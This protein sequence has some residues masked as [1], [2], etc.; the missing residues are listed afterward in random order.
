MT[1]NASETD[2]DGPGVGGYGGRIRR[3][4]MAADAHF[5]QISNAL[6]RDPRVSFKAK[7]I[8]GLIS[9]HRDGFGIKPET[10]AKAGTEGVAAIKTALQ[11]LER[12]G[13][14][15]RAQA[16]RED[17][18]LG[19]VV[20]YITDMPRSEP[21]DDN[22][23]PVPTS[24]VGHN[25]RSEPVD[26]YPLADEPPAVN[27][28]HKNTNS[29]HTK[30]KNT[31]SPRLPQQTAEE[32]PAT[33]IDERET[34]PEDQILAAYVLALGRPVASSIGNTI[35]DQAAKLLADGLPLWWLIARAKELPQF[36][37]DLAKHCN[38]SR[39]PV[40]A[41][42]PDGLA[43]PCDRHDKNNRMV[44]DRH[45]DLVNCPDCHPAE[46]ARQQRQGAA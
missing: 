38:M 29:K 12:F 7:G 32:P 23:P 1:V 24:E 28:R 19:P 5:T 17:G 31:L 36:G 30:L 14:L 39:A 8:F 34:S 2:P 25:R 45:G 43:P 37:T 20:Y 33:D 16:R 40:E 3:G 18:T 44:R 9:T 21:V 22:R 42:R 10:I 15:D 46:L 26:D 35:R 11:E 4:P 27:R 6:F 41:R 13:Y